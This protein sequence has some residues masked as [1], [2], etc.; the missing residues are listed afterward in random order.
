MK[1]KSVRKRID[2]KDRSIWA[3]SERHM[4]LSARTHVFQMSN[5]IMVILSGINS[6][7]YH[8]VWDEVKERLNETS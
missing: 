3:A 6:L 4:L 1:L 5:R 2:I 7:R 8:M